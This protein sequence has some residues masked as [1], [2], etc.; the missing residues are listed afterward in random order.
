MS[1]VRQLLS[2]LLLGAKVGICI[3]VGWFLLIYLVR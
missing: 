3:F 1:E 2:G